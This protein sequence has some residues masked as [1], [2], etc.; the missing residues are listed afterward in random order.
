MAEIPMDII[1]KFEIRKSKLFF[2][3]LCQ[4]SFNGLSPLADEDNEF[5]DIPCHTPSWY[6]GIVTNKLARFSCRLRTEIFFCPN[7]TMQMRVVDERKSFIGSFLNL[8]WR[9]LLLAHAKEG[10]IIRIEPENAYLRHGFIQGTH[11]VHLLLY[12]FFGH[13]ILYFCYSIIFSIERSLQHPRALYIRQ[14]PG[15]WPGLAVYQ[16]E[17]V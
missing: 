17:G 8:L 5:I 11:S 2:Y 16:N 3:H 1:N 9:K 6:L 10:V 15:W 12:F 13:D 7:L 14:K 4:F